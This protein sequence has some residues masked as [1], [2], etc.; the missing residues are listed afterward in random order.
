ME[1]Q[2]P[3][4]LYRG[5]FGTLLVGSRSKLNDRVSLYEETRRTTGYGQAGLLHAFGVDLVLTERWST[6]LKMETDAISDP[7]NGDIK[8]RVV[9]LSMGYNA[10]V[11]A[12]SL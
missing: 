8:R 6:G 5:R 12:S 4:Q 3:D 7:L 1:T 2:H 11:L 10:T 9:A